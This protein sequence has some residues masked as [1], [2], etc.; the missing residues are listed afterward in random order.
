MGELHI[1][2]YSEIVTECAEQDSKL[3]SASIKLQDITLE[4]LGVGK[5]FQ[6]NDEFLTP[7]IQMISSL[8]FIPTFLSFFVS[9]F[10]FFFSF[11]FVFH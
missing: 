5:H 8:G 9:L 1:H 4:S 3:V 11:F 10:L 6:V 2:I 7:S